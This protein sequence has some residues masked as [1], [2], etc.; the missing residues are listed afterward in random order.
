MTSYYP[1]E[2]EEPLW[3]IMAKV[4]FTLAVSTKTMKENRLR[5]GVSVP[6]THPFFFG[7][8]TV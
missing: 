2:I 8:T 4:L 7:L 3:Q 1:A 6:L 5:S